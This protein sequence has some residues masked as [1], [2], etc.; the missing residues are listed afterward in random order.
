MLGYQKL[1]QHICKNIFLQN[2]RI[3][4]IWEKN[5]HIYIQE[6]T[7]INFLSFYTITNEFK[8]NLYKKIE[9]YNKNNYDKVLLSDE[10]YIGH[11][12][13]NMLNYKNNMESI[14]CL[15][16]NAKIIITIRRQ[17]TF[18]ESAYRYRVFSKGIFSSFFQYINY[19]GENF[20]PYRERSYENIDIKSLDW[21]NIIKNYENI[22]SKKNVFVIPYELL[23]EDKESFFKLICN[24]LGTDIP[25]NIEYKSSNKGFNYYAVMVAR[26]LNRFANNSRNGFCFIIQNPLVRILPPSK[27]GENKILSFL[28][29]IS[30]KIL[31]KNIVKPLNFITKDKKIIS[32]ELSKKI[33]DIHYKNNKVLSEERGLNLDKFGYF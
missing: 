31:I 9:F 30:S 17:D 3:F 4:Y 11:I 24:F 18:L 33:M 13:K 14:N 32:N 7:E 23:K 8:E 26:F 6:L 25:T 10:G 16:P 19:N 12:D 20:I 1:Q 28:R 5:L 22:F 29:K 27:E 21:L 2:L 15:F